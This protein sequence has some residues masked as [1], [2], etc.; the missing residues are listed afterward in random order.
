MLASHKEHYLRNENRVSEKNYNNIHCPASITEE[1]ST[2]TMAEA[3]KDFD[4]EEQ[5]I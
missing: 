4:I 5:L 1:I 2:R 3:I